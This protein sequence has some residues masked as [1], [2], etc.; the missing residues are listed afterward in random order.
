MT[1]ILVTLALMR[2]LEDGLLRL[3]DTVGYFLPEYKNAGYDKTGIT[4]FELLTHTS[5]ISSLHRLYRYAHTREDVCEAIFLSENRTDGR[6]L[7]TCEG[8]IVLGEIVSRIDGAP[9]DEV[10][11][12]RV[13]EP[14]GM[15]DTGY[16]PPAALMERIAPT[17]Y[18]RWREKLV[19]GQVHD[20][21]AVVLGGVSGNAGIF[22]TA[23]DI[24]K[25]AAMMLN[26]KAGGSFLHQVTIE[27]MTR[28][29]TEGKGSNRGLG[30]LLAGPDA[31]GGDLMS[32]RSFGHTG[33]TGTSI[34]VDPDAG[35]YGILLA[36]RVHPTR[37]NTAF[38]R[39]RPIF[40][41]LVMLNYGL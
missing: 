17:E 16:N 32:S 1:K 15:K 33:F 22:S 2:Q 4:L 7:Y 9:L 29:Y 3:N 27:K 31:S 36:N 25:I 8:Y 35:L 20:E 19:R 26:P 13:L 28:N 5:A 24:A 18:C 23:A 40:H 39:V 10:V 6:V 34:W 14:L 38:V 11:R 30:W 21:T 41:H 12:K 37:E